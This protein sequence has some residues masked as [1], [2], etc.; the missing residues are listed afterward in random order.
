MSDSFDYIVVGSGSAGAALAARLSEDGRHTVL[1][2]EAGPGEG[3][4]L[5]TRMPMATVKVA[6]KAKLMRKFYTE[7]DPQLN[8]RQIYW[9]RG[10]V[11]GGSSTVNGMMWV[12]G[13]PKQYDAWASDGCPGWSYADVLPWLRKVEDYPAGD[14]IYRGHDGPVTI[15]EFKPVDAMPDAFLDGVA[16]AGIAPRVKDYNARGFGAGYVQFNTR[17]GMRCGTRMAYLD[18]ALTRPNFTL[19]SGV[20]VT[21]V[22]LEGKRAVAVRARIPGHAGPGQAAQGQEGQFNARRE[23][24]LS[25]GTFNSAQLLELS[26]IGGARALSGA[27][28]PLVHEL[29]MVGENLSEHVY[30]PMTYRAKPGVS[31]NRALSGK[32]GQAKLGWRWLTRRDGPLTTVGITANAFASAQPDGTD[33]DIKLQV[34]QLST[35]NNRSGGKVVL[36]DFEGV[37]LA[38]FQ[39]C[40]RSRGS[41][42]ITSSDPI[43]NPKMLSQHFT[44]LDDIQACLRGLQYV[45][46][47]AGTAALGA[48]LDGEVRPGSGSASDEALIAHIRAT[49]ATAYHP[50]GSCRIGNDA[51]Q[52]VVDPQLRVHGIQ[53]LRVADA[54][55]MPSIAS[56]NT[57]AICIAIGE[58]AAGFILSA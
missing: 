42:H 43:A 32:W 26:G 48:V 23:I 57:N 15:T 8:G 21:R 10:W 22:V 6:E 1:L 25:G 24:I 2:L 45:R 51:T 16:A 47:A 7:A 54:S 18:E 33:A 36:D 4:S 12:H 39:I 46:R 44:H 11:I 56:T 5:M 37:T 50:V 28:V 14:R 9:P 3:R 35:G 53:G 41:T 17:N 20:M 52:S 40:P 58:R 30:T 34:Q 55:V 38:S 29:P 49:G 13:T 19:R 27:G 31:W